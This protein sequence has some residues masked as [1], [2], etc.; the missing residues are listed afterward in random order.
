MQTYFTNRQK[1]GLSNQIQGIHSVATRVRVN[2]NDNADWY[3]YVP[4]VG[5]FG[6]VTQD[7][8]GDLYEETSYYFR[9]TGN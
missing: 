6:F 8:D 1:T 9:K 5:W 7:P 4:I 3:S 2:F